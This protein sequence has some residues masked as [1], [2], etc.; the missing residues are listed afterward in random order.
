MDLALKIL[1]LIILLCAA[2]IVFC[3]TVYIVGVGIQE[4]I[5]WI[6]ERMEE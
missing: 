4:L 5:E 2:I 3:L 1:M 6:R